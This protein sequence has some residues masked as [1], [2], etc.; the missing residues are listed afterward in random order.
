MTAIP[1]FSPTPEQESEFTDHIIHLSKIFYGLTPKDIRRAA[2][3]FADRNQ[4]KHSFNKESKI[5]GKDWFHGFNRRNRKL[6]TRKPEATSIN[7]IL[8]FNRQEVGKFFENLEVV[9]EKSKFEPTEIWNM[10]ETGI[11]TVKENGV[12][13]AEKGQNSWGSH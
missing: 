4:I 10:D 1:P 2:F 9:Y 6:S 8:G 3:S 7:R 11:S 5:A 12:V 13:V